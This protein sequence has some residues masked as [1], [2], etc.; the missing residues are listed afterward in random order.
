MHAPRLI[1]QDDIS[2]IQMSI[3]AKITV[4]NHSYIMS[5]RSRTQMN[6]RHK[7]H[8]CTLQNMHFLPTLTHLTALYGKGS[9]K[10]I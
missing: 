2:R 7:N 5:T 9:I 1:V 4:A 8:S 10:S 6:P 3:L